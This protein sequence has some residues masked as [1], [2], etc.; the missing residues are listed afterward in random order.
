MPKK[1]AP[2]SSGLV[3]SKGQAKPAADATGRGAAPEPAE[4]QAGVPLNFRVT[5]AFR[6]EF[7]MFAAAHDLK[8]NQLLHRAFEAFRDAQKG[9]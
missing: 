1:H 4:A 6:R 5:P 8:L 2:L 3:A 9:Q 7:K